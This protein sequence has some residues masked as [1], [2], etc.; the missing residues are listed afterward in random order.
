MVLMY[1]MKDCGLLNEMFVL[2][3]H[4]VSWINHDGL[5][6]EREVKLTSCLIY[7]LLS[8]LDLLLKF[9]HLHS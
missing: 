3:G 2:S 1:N 9:R 8:V 7:H 5:V 6:S 4:N